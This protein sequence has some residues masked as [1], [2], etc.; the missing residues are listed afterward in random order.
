MAIVLFQGGLLIISCLGVVKVM[1]RLC[2]FRSK[3][4]PS[5]RNRITFS[6]RLSP[7]GCLANNKPI[8]LHLEYGSG[9]MSIVTTLVSAFYYH[10]FRS[11][12]KA[13]S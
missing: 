3:R 11:S 8:D 4:L 1:D 13:A 2:Y 9:I 10:L 6:C 12:L 7:C 5:F